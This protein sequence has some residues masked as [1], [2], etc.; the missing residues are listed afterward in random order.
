MKES[1]LRSIHRENFANSPILNWRQQ[2]LQK[3]FEIGFPKKREENWKYTHLDSLYQQ[4]FD[5]PPRSRSSCDLTARDLT[6]KFQDDILENCYQLVFIDG[7]YQE[8]LSTIHE[9]SHLIKF[10]CSLEAILKEEYSAHSSVFN[11]L[12]DA[13]FQDGLFLQIPKDTIIDKPIRL[14]Y[15]NTCSNSM[16][17]PRHAVEVG[18]N[19]QVIIWEE[20][21]GLNAENYFNNTVTQIYLEE[22]A[23][24]TY[25]KL[26]C[27][28]SSAYHIGNTQLSLAKDSHLKAF[29]FALGGKIY[30][31]DLNVVLKQ[32][33]AECQLT[34]FY[35]PKKNQHHDFHT[36]ID[37]LA[38]HTRS[39]Q[40]YKGI[41]DN[42]GRAVFNGKIVVH[43]KAQQVNAEQNNKNI[44]LSVDG[45]VDTKPELEIFADN[46][47][48]RHGAT[49]G[50]LAENA[51]FYLQS[52][53]IPESIARQLLLK[54]FIEEIFSTMDAEFSEYVRSIVLTEVANENQ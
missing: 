11:Y 3:F 39:A 10:D 5:Y 46:V 26:Q 12:N 15:L 20:H 44:L 23:R 24:L 41:I 6:S 22:N 1:S 53:G 27:E 34:G 33:G 35:G 19:S 2:R 18:S 16:C 43:P 13:F 54:G 49:V 37:H 21:K 4:D 48:C 9:L 40:L 31:E 45:E 7:F 47:Q 52:R 42:N 29:H 14:L 25:Y 38:A 8:Q 51:L 17:Y 36:R 32:A 28:Q 50:Q 30:R